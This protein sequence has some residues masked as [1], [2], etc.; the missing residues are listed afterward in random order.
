MASFTDTITADSSPRVPELDGIRGIAILLVLLWHYMGS[1]IVPRTNA[2]GDLLSKV[3]ATAWSGVDLFFVLSGFLIGGI[4]LDHRQAPHYFKAFYARRISRIFPLYFSWLILFIGLIW[5]APQFT[6]TPPLAELFAR[7]MPLWTY[8]TFT[9]NFAMGA[10]STLGPHWLGITWSLAVE[11]Q[12][13]MLLPMLICFVSP[14]RLPLTLLAFILFSPPLRGIITFLVGNPVPAYV[15]MPFRADALMLGVLCAYVVRQKHLK[16]LLARHIRIL[17]SALVVL[18]MGV[19]FLTLNFPTAGSQEM[20]IG[21][22]TVFA[23]FY[24][25]FLLVAITE[26]QGIVTA[27]ARNKLLR[28]L[29]MLAYGV[30]MFH[31]AVIWFV[32]GLILRQVP[33][34]QTLPDVLLTLVAFGIVLLIASISWSL[35]E[36]KIIRWGHRV[37]YYDHASAEA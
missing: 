37:E 14:Q 8:L 18:L 22:Y 2:L 30:Y 9:Q 13:Y 26:R 5:S 34:I 4:L 33:R 28:W 15:L 19:V 32:H 3:T 27:I 20:L 35:F 7:P 16:D 36:K 12:F 6:S 21:G 11:E 10:A 25:C 31:Q 1:I 29:G 24:S 17:Y 23:L